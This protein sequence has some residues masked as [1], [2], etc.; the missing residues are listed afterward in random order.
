M[1]CDAIGK[2]GLR[3]RSGAMS[4]FEKCFFHSKDPNH[5][6]LRL[7]GRKQGGIKVQAHNR[8]HLARRTADISAITSC[9][10]LRAVIAE[11][12]SQV[13]RGEI[14]PRIGN[15]I[16]YLLSVAMVS[17]QQSGSA[18]THVE[19]IVNAPSGTVPPSGMLPKEKRIAKPIPE[20]QAMPAGDEP[21]QLREYYAADGRPDHDIANF[22][23]KPPQEDK[24]QRQPAPDQPQDQP[25]FHQRGYGIP[26][27][28]IIR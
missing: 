25:E 12:I 21:R 1:Q 23:V 15:T 20:R 28:A 24:P 13:R 6:K 2:S 22:P 3:C 8:L 18:P 19:F 4:G 17:L 26:T 7:A 10:E 9:E 11:T 5:V 14:E 27:S 16:G